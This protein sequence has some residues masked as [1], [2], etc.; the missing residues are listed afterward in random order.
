[1]IFLDFHP[2][3]VAFP[4]PSRP[5][6]LQVELLMKEADFASMWFED[7]GLGARA[8]YRRWLHA[9]FEVLRSS[10]QNVDAVLCAAAALSSK[11][12]EQLGQLLPTLRSDC[13]LLACSLRALLEVKTPLEVPPVVDVLLEKRRKVK[14]QMAMEFQRC[15]EAPRH[16][17]SMA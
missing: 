13:A 3:F 8:R 15:H 7:L 17:P 6:H 14:Q 16:G 9:Y 12:S 1:M 2:F 5:F 4:C 10:L 11:E